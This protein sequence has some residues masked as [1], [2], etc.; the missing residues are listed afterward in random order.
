MTTT[1][2]RNEVNWAGNYRYEARRI[3]VPTGVDELRALVLEAKS[4]RALGS[5]HSFNGLADTADLLISTAGLPPEIR[6]DTESRSVRVG[7]GVRYGDL[8]QALQAAGWA[9]PNLASL[10]HISVAG[11]VATAT[12]GSGDANGNLSTAVSGMTILRADGESVTLN[13]GDPDFDGAVVSLGALGI[14]VELTLD[15]LPTFDVRQRLFAGLP[16]EAAIHSYDQISSSAYSVSLFTTWDED[17]VSLAWVKE[18]VSDGE[19]VQGEFFGAKPLTVP[20]HMIVSIDPKNATEQLGVPGPWSE[21]L[22]HFRY[23]FTPS[24]GEEIQS[25]YLF[26]RERVPEVF[27]GLRSLGPRISEHLQISEI[28]S[29][30]A[31]ELWLSSS[32]RADVVGVHFT[33]VRDQA[34]VE[35]ILP[36]VESLLFPLGGR[37]HW[38]KVFLDNER[39]LP[40]MYPRLTQFRD[41]QLRFDPD[42]KFRNH[43]LNR[44]LD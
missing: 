2:N 32:Y 4:V 13:R 18:R 19:G 25:E 14:V 43:F 6:I 36:Q 11:A 21:R 38:G 39:A 15:I 5:R 12:H 31:D 3:A 23:E 30:A 9:L 34:A 24:A 33:W 10:P 44:L 40:S 42:G 37:P 28:R 17:E 8:A 7:G 29:V 27:E 16:W 26:P 41:L 35:S 20:R 1:I 22:A